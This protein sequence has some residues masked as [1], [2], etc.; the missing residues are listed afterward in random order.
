MRKNVTMARLINLRSPVVSGWPLWALLGVFQA[1]KDFA[2]VASQRERIA[3]LGVLLNRP[4]SKPSESELLAVTSKRRR[5][6]VLDVL[7]GLSIEETHRN[8]SEK[9]RKRS[10]GF[11]QALHYLLQNCFDFIC[12]AGRTLSFM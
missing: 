1:R 11:V 12:N 2:V 3:V 5:R 7:P 4:L 8:D 6:A 9:L 10:I